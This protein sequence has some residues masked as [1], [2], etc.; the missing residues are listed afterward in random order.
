MARLNL[1]IKKKKPHQMR[2]GCGFLD[3]GVHID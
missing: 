3:V 1:A 2:I